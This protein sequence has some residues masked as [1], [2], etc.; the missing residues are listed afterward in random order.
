M[1]GDQPAWVHE[2]ISGLELEH[3]NLQAEAWR[4][5]TPAGHTENAIK[6]PP[7]AEKGE[8]VMKRPVTSK[9]QRKG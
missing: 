5:K 9:N 7:A 3:Q 6:P 2:A 8:V 4:P 1:M